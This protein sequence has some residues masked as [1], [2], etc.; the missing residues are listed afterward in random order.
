VKKFIELSIIGVIILGC[1]IPNSSTQG[2]SLTP[3]APDPQGLRL[4]SIHGVLHVQKRTSAP[5]IMQLGN[6]NIRAIY[7]ACRSARVAVVANQTSIIGDGRKGNPTHLV[8]TLLALGIDVKKVFAP[9]HGFRGNAHNGAHIQDSTDPK[10]G[11]PILSL[12]GKNKK[13]TAESLADVRIIL[14]DIQ[15]VGARFYT[16]LSSLYLVMEAAAEQN[17]MVMVLDRPNP[18]GHQIAGPI[19][20]SQWT[21]FV[22]K[23]PVPVVHGMT[24]GEMAKMIN[25][26]GW[27]KG[28]VS[29]DLVIIPCENYAH[30]DAWYPQIPPSPNLPTAESIALYPSLCPFEPT[31]ASI[32]RG[33]PHPFECVGLPQF[34]GV[35]SMGSFAF[36]PE[37][38]PNAAPHPKHEGLNCV[39]Q[40]LKGLGTHWTTSEVGFD[41][42]FVYE[43]SNDWKKSKSDVAFVESP[44][45]LAK[46]TGNEEMYQVIQGK[47]TYNDMVAGWIEELHEFEVS[48]TPYLLYPM[49]RIESN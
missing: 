48:R 9:E 5:E 12:H 37:P 38:V 35:I 42:S 27:L 36:T 13:P 17:K 25:G 46:L 34:D 33:T 22:G 44:N 29:C 6:E 3:L 23:I 45:F 21:S 32:G 28:G 1:T 39:G 30:S 41:W 20:D 4:D 24:L 31:V 2:Q 8:D 26:E 43:Y 47:M 15:D 10:T 14:F 18:H 7:E 11:L 40:N 19:I 49:Q 16:Y